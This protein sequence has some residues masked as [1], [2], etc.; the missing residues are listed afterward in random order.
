MKL[1]SLAYLS[2]LATDAYALGTTNRE[3]D[4]ITPPIYVLQTTRPALNSLSKALDT[5]GYV[6][7]E[8]AS[9]ATTATPLTYAEVSP[10]VQLVE[11]A[12]SRPD[13][14]FIV[15]RVGPGAG[16]RRSGSDWE[17]ISSEHHIRQ[18]LSYFPEDK[19]RHVVHLDVLTPEAAAQADN[20][21]RLCEFL[22]MGYSTVERMKLWHFPE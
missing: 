14:R 20:W 16:R 2:V 18:A 15:P 8:D 3:R 6:R 13:A 7:V 11:I 4:A 21:I 22:G 9:N 19:R 12:R 1:S 5:L 10:D 17:L